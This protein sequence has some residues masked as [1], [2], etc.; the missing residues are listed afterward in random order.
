MTGTYVEFPVTK[1]SQGHLSGWFSNLGFTCVSHLHVTTVYSRVPIDYKSIYTP[2]ITVYPEELSFLFLKGS[3]NLGLCL[4]LGVSNQIFQRSYKRAVSLGAVWDYPS[5]IPHITL[6]YNTE[7][8]SLLEHPLSLPKFP[9]RFDT[10]VVLPL[11][12]D[13]KPQRGQ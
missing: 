5:F 1:T 7:I 12:E 13:L 2:P 8:E 3:N 10:E 11:D 4:C 6:T 9:V